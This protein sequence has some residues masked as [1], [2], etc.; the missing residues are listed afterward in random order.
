MPNYTLIN[1][2]KGMFLK[3]IK[4]ILI[5]LALVNICEAVIHKIPPIEDSHI[6][7]G[8]GIE[9]SLNP[10]SINIIV[11]NI[12]KSKRKNWIEDF[13]Y[14]SKNKDILILQ[15]GLLNERYQSFYTHEMFEYQFDM[16]VS[17]LY[18]KKSPTGTMIGSKV[19][20][21][22]TTIIRTLYRE[23]IVKTPKTSIYSIYDI[24]G[25]SKK[26]LVVS[27]HGL[28]FK[29]NIY[30][31]KQIRAI[32]DNISHHNGPIIFAGDF[33]TWNKDRTIFLKSIMKENKFEEAIFD[34]DQRMKVFGY[35]LDY[36]FLK[37]IYIKKA[38]VLS[39]IKS[40]D[41]APLSLELYLR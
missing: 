20:P 27:I 1:A 24:E 5:H 40:S 19:K 11:W 9:R 29:K 2:I 21:I 28:N 14:I 31:K 7:I 4:I 30:L 12:L 23:P 33:N 8:E 34:R 39:S 3:Y 6:T 13:L 18:L 35:P 16:A 38:E 41:H 36:V 32:F 10:N 25:K 22:S 26:L 17:F 37:D 15:E